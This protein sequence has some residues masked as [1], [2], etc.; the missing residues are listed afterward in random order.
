MIMFINVINKSYSKFYV[1]YSKS[2]LYLRR[3]VEVKFRV[4]DLLLYSSQSIS[5]DIKHSDSLNKCSI[6]TSCIGLLKIKFHLIISLYYIYLLLYF[7]NKVFD[8]F[9]YAI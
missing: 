3:T 5:F 9:S 4:D 6:S 1:I 8:L 2:E 7:L